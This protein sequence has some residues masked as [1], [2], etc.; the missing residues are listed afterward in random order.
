MIL[1][2]AIIILQTILI[3]LFFMIRSDRNKK[4]E[5][6]RKCL[7][8]QQNIIKKQR[9]LIEKEILKTKQNGE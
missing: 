3:I 7:N 9:A 8:I 2:I 4:M 5:K 1:S 6:I